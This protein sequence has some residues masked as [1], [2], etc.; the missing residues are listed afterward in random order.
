MTAAPVTNKISADFSSRSG[1]SRSLLRRLDQ[2]RE[3]LDGSFDEF[4]FLARAAE[5]RRGL[6]EDFEGLLRCRLLLV[7]GFSQT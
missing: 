3:S 5:L 1:S 7:H 6:C 4:M 2:W